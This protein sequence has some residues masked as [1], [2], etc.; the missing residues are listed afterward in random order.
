MT[1]GGSASFNGFTIKTSDSRFRE[2]G[3]EMLVAATAATGTAPTDGTI[4]QAQLEPIIQAASARWSAALGG[5][6][7]AG[8]LGTIVFAVGD[9]KGQALAQTVG[10]VVMLDLN[11]AGHGWFI[12]STPTD[13]REFVTRN[14]AGELRAQSSSIALGRMDLLTAVMHE[15]GHV[16]GFEHNT[17]AV[18][19]DVMTPSL[20]TGMRRVPVE[21]RVHVNGGGASPTSASMTSSAVSASTS[22]ATST[23]SI[24][25]EAPTTISSA[26][27][28]TP[29][30]APSTPVPPGQKNG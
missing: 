8:V 2:A 18:E 15:I 28:T 13:D 7:V 26:P 11:G 19:P 9:L 3:P 6:D 22:A 10:R 21:S 5:G 12:D 27:A 25:S 4:T 20:S 17:N 14:G 16:L 1:K 24:H 30:L 23:P 29:S